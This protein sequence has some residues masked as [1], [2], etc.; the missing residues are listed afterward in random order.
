MS[1]NSKLK[2][3]LMSMA[4]SCLYVTAQNPIVQT[5]YTTDPAPLV[6]D[7]RMYVYTGHDED[8]ADFFWMQEWR[9]YSSDDMVRKTRMKKLK[10]TMPI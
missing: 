5:C 6:H 3:V 2:C 10:S 9:I 4:A 8:K 7:G 1:M